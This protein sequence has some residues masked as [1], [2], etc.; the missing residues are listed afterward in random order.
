VSFT[1]GANAALDGGGAAVKPFDGVTGSFAVAATDKTGRDFRAKGRLEYVGK[2]FLQFA[3]TKEFFLKAGA[4]A[5]E[6]FLAYVDFDDTVA[7]KPKVPLK[8][9]SA[10]LK[11]W[12]AGDP[13]WKDGKGK[14]MI[15]ALNYLAGKGANSFSF[16]TYNAGGDG[17]NVWPFVQ[18]DDKLHYDCSKL[19]Q[20]QIVFDHSQKLGLY[21]HFKTQRKL[22]YR[23]LVARFGHELALNWN[24]GEENTQTPEQQRAEIAY[25]AGIDPYQHHRVIH[26]YPNEQDKVYP[27]LIGDKSLLTG[28]S[29]QNE[30]NHAH[31]RTLKWVTE[32]D[33]A[34]KPWVV[35]NDEQGGADSGVPPDLGYAGYD[36][37]KKDGQAV[38]TTH[39]IRKATLWGN[40]MAGGAG[41]EYYFGYQLPENDL[42]CQDWRSRDKSWDYARI[43]LEFFRENRIPF[44]EMKNA[45]ALIGNAANKN[46]KYC[47]AKSGE[48]YLVFLAKGGTTDLDMR[49]VTG[50]FTVKWF[51]PR[52]GGKLLDGSVKSVKGGGG[53]S[54]GQPPTD[55]D[56]DWVV[57]VR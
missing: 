36:G 54:L 2:H 47:L 56:Q 31:Q 32:S 22:Y 42:I 39:D 5:P 19:D 15:G 45:N 14:G 20:W 29:L 50:S 27:E 55:A 28:A 8:T 25:V 40:L 34:G 21:L 48:V 9:W 18:R 26:T 52:T 43:A 44:W 53:V 17:D 38:Q 6:T 3:G 41:V 37:K 33:K 51:N 30:W 46:D 1:R 24:F 13:T 12:K 7:N 57:L 11:D 4:D 16:L 35:A 49:G 10:H 23:E